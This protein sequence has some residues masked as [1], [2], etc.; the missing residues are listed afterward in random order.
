MHCA[1]FICCNTVVTRCHSLP[2]IVTHYHSLYDSLSLFVTCCTA[3]YHS[4]SLDVP[5]A[6]IR[7]LFINDH[8]LSMK[9]V[10]KFIKSIKSLNVK[11]LNVKVSECPFKQNKNMLQNMTVLLYTYLY[12]IYINVLRPTFFNMYKLPFLR[13]PNIGKIRVKVGPKTNY[14]SYILSLTEL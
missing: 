5:L 2:F 13:S 4:L 14:F 6:V 7:C 3:R 8:N 12:N 1:V 11:L 9:N 10:I